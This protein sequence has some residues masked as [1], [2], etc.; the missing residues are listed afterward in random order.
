[1]RWVLITAFG[2]FVDP[3]VKRNFTIV[4]GPVASITRA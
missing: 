3:L 2:R 1:M 4:S